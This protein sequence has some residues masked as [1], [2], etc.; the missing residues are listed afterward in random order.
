M[1]LSP[2]FIAGLF[3]WDSVGCMNLTE[4]FVGVIRVKYVRSRLR[5]LAARGRG[6]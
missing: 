5:A 1:E 2:G 3:G 6:A 4:C